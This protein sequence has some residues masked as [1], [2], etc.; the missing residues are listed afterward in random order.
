MLCVLR[1]ALCHAVQARAVAAMCGV[2]PAP[3]LAGAQASTHVA[4]LR[5]AL[6]EGGLPLQEEVQARQ[7]TWSIVWQAIQTKHGQYFLDFPFNLES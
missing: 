3:G 6:W 5:A 7:V 4:P 2:L 1:H